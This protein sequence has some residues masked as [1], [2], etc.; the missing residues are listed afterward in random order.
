L[1]LYDPSWPIRT[2]QP[3]LPPPKFVFA[4]Q[5]GPN[6]RR[7]IALDSMVC[8]GSIIS[9]GK[10][11]RS[12]IGHGVRISSWCSVEDSILFDGVQLGREVQIRRAIIDKYVQIPTGT[13][14]GFDPEEDRKNGYTVTGTGITVIPSTL[15]NADSNL[16]PFA[17][18][19]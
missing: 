6:P 7:G 11:E 9:G 5:A 14:I 17:G 15:G 3:S 18:T 1:N 16:L 8:D 12:I 19:G 10:V 2:Y 13:R 4:Q